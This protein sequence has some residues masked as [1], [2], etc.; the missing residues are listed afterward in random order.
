[1]PETRD[2]LLSSHC[3]SA[4]NN[5]ALCMVRAAR[6][7]SGGWPRI[8]A[9]MAYSAAMRCNASNA[10]GDWVDACTSKNFR[11]ACARHAASVTP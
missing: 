6:R 4:V 11:R 10:S 2:R 8:V 1:L 3:R 7:A 9:S 5:D